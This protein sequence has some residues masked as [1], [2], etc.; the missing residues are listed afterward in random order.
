MEDMLEQVYA[1][2]E[3]VNM[4]VRFTPPTKGDGK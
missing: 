2:G 3:P 1:T 4:I